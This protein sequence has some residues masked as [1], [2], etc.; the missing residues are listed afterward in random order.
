M[1]WIKR[2]GSGNDRSTP[3]LLI[4]PYPLPHPTYTPPS[5]NKFHLIPTNPTSYPHTP[6]TYPLISSH[7][8]ST[9]PYKVIPGNSEYRVIRNK[10]KSTPDISRSTRSWAARL[11]TQVGVLKGSCSMFLVWM[12][13]QASWAVGLF[14]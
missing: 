8:H 4:P 5:T 10:L 2:E 14:S 6:T 1:A 3:Y 12:C 9:P 7:T 11:H 13:S